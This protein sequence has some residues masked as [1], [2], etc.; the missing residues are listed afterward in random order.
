M[1]NIQHR[2]KSLEKHSGVGI[3]ENVS[4]VVVTG[5]LDKKQVYAKVEKAITEYKATHPECSVRR[6]MIWHLQDEKT[7]DLFEHISDRLLGKVP[8]DGEDA[9]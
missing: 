8:S 2:I 9:R 4:L 7:K 1:N 5:G 6:F 3:Q